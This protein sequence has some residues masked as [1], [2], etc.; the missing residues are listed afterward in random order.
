VRWGLLGFLIGWFL[1]GWW[2]RAAAGAGD[3]QPAEGAP[4]TEVPPAAAFAQGP[5][6]SAR[7]TPTTP[8]E[9]PEEQA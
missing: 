2:Q 4:M 7:E 6:E 9:S 3:G 5:I 1:R 8:Y